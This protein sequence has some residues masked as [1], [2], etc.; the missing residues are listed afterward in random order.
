MLTVDAS[1]WVAVRDPSEPFFSDSER[2]FERLGE[3]DFRIYS[4]TL[5]LVEVAAA[6][7]RKSHNSE[8]GKQAALEV[9][10]IVEQRWVPLDQNV[11]T[12]AR[13]MASGSF[14]RGADAV[15]AAVAALSGS[16]LV[17]LDR[18]LAQRAEGLVPSVTP[19]EWLRLMSEGHS[20][21]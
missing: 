1:V 14:L 3:I 21:G 10:S 17:T 12:L 20:D 5:L 11:A 13:D 18:E 2:F 19:A 15:Y 8:L 6:I 7:A 4:P 9:A 16:M